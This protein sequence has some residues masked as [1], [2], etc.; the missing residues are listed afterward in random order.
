MTILEKITQ[1]QFAT[2]VEQAPARVMVEF[3]AEWCAPCKRL[4]PILV[5]LAARWNGKLSMLS[6]DVDECTDLTM[7][8]Q[9]MSVPTVI[10]FSEG[11]PVQRIL[12]LQSKERIIEKIEPF[13]D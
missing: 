9:I 4:E 6:M 2:R 7:R 3:G 12:G 1:E 8:F 13:L 5:D 10:L 11:Q